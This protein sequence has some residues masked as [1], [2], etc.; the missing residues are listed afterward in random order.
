MKCDFF[1]VITALV[2]AVILFKKAKRMTPS[3]LKLP[4][5]KFFDHSFEHTPRLWASAEN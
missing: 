3:S 5:W 4:P 2:A 1:A